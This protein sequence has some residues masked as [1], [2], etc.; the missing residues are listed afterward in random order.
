MKRRRRARDCSHSFQSGPAHALY[1][2]AGSTRPPLADVAGARDD[3][4]RVRLGSLDIGGNTTGSQTAYT[5]YGQG[6]AG[7][8]MTATKRQ[9]QKFPLN[10][11][12]S[13]VATKNHRWLSPSI[14]SPDDEFF[15]LD[16][17]WTWGD[18]LVLMSMPNARARLATDLDR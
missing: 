7:A 12:A 14:Q 1:D 6:G 2:I 13:V 11:V 3:P 4:G 5:S 18:V 8:T 9:T 10:I 16:H 17:T 15:P